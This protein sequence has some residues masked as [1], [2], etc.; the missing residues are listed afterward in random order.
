M[1][2]VTITGKGGEQKEV[3]IRKT[4]SGDLM[5]REHPEIDI[6]VMPEKG[7]VL[8][9]PKDEQTDHIYKLQEKLFKYM[10]QKGVILPE[11]VFSGNV[12]GSLQGNYAKDTQLE[13]I[14]PLQVVVYNLANFIEDE[15]PAFAYEQAYEDAMEKELLR[16]DTEDSTELGEVPQEPFKG[17]IPKYGFPTRGIY[18]YNY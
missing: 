10:I 6:V 11:S 15:R 18:R 3:N 13:G 2:K 5:L 9:L 4:L 8:V 7:K 14:D 17:S 1:I 12:Y 16:P